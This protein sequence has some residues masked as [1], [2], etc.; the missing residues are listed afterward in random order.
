MSNQ[1]L[2]THGYDEQEVR[3]CLQKMEK[4]DY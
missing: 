2:T 4:F 3:V 1:E